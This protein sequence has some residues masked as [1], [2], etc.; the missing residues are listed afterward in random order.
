MVAS[1]LTVALLLAAAPQTA[2]P[3]EWEDPAVF[4][5]GTE[6][7]RATF[8]PHAT[9]AGALSHERERSPY[10]RLLNGTWRFRWVKSPSAAPPAFEQPGYDDSGWDGLPVPSNWQVVGANEGRPYDRPFFSNIRHPFRTDPPRVPHDDNPTGL[11]RTRFELPPTWTGRNVVLHF[12]G[13]QSAYYVWLNGRRIGYREDAFTP[14]EF[15]LTPH[16]RP[17][18]NVLAVEVLH[19]SDGSYLEDQDY[20]RLAGIFR[21]VYLLAQPAVRLR[22]FVVRTD[23]DASYRDA[24]LALEI[25]LENRSADAASGHSVAAALL[26]PDGVEAWSGSLSVPDAAPGQEARARLVARV[27]SPRLWSAEAPH[28]YTLV[29]DHRGG[30]G[31]SLEVVATRIGFR[32]VEIR[33][34]QL[35]LNGVAI[36][37]KGANRHEFDPD[38]G[39]VVPR[40]RMIEDIRLMKQHSFNAVRTSHYPNDPLFLELCDEYGL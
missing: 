31:A 39:R 30:G 37:F 13:V 7:P 26:A 38:H 9:R 32:E 11:Y 17:G 14:G 22:D 1:P 19:H 10:V 4:A 24:T 40:E 33:G 36:T 18:E 8:V 15:D 2:P 23:L 29:L 20:W 21:E 16:L 3:P 25:A 6:R 12:A 34:G 5:V 35:L 28:L 27:A